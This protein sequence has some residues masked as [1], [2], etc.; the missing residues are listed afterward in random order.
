M[1][2]RVRSYCSRAT[3]VQGWFPFQLRVQFGITHA[4]RGKT[5]KEHKNKSDKCRERN[6]GLWYPWHCVSW[7]VLWMAAC[8]RLQEDPWDVEVKGTEDEGGHMWQAGDIEDVP[9]QKWNTPHSMM[10]WSWFC[11]PVNLMELPFAISHISSSLFCPANT[12]QT[13]HPV[14]FAVIL[15]KLERT[16]ILTR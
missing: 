3:A 11:L 15:Q 14:Q 2:Q 16:N 12:I 13:Q 6:R 7:R 1:P 8:I 5:N 10:L 4:F 9:G